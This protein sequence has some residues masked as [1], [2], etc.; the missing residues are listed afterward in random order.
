MVTAFFLLLGQWDEEVPPLH[1]PHFSLWESVR[2][3]RR[4]ACRGGGGSLQVYGPQDLLTRHPTLRFQQ[5]VRIPTLM[6]LLASGVW[7]FVLQVNK[8]QVLNL[9]CEH[10]LLQILG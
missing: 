3:P 10:T 9:P 1:P 6:F 7:W 4:K 2:A 5:F 8:F